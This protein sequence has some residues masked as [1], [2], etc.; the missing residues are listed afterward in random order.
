MFD[1][2]ISTG[3]ITRHGLQHVFA[4]EPRRSRDRA[5]LARPGSESGVESLLRQ[6]L[7]ARGHLIEQ[8]VFVPGVGTVDFRVD[9]VLFVEVDGFLFHSD[10][11]AF[12]HDRKR[13]TAMTLR[14]ERRL[15][16]SAGEVIS[17]GEDV[18]DTIEAVLD[19]TKRE[20]ERALR[21][22]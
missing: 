1:T 7:S 11:L 19:R 5:A 20:E 21:R 2:A 9:G 15:R 16:F 18:V 10:R 12:A 8:Q 13:D 3:R 14:G 17:R 6:R 22:G 4:Q